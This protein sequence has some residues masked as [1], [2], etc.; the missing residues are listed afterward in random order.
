M[1]SVPKSALLG[2]APSAC[3]GSRG[4]L[5]SE[6]EVSELSDVSDGVSAPGLFLVLGEAGTAIMPKIRADDGGYGDS[7]RQTAETPRSRSV[8]S[9]QRC[10]VRCGTRKKGEGEIVLTSA[11]DAVLRGRRGLLLLCGGVT[12]WRWTIDT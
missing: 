10:D 3:S 8:P 9:I 7:A 11:M 4:V 5:D 1:V 12:R 6:V 2:K